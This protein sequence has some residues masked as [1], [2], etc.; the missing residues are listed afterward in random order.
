M[1]GDPVKA[2]FPEFDEEENFI[3]YMEHY[4]K[5]RQYLKKNYNITLSALHA[6][7]KNEGIY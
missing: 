1:G 6:C 7:I 2:R 3:K 5:I 4:P